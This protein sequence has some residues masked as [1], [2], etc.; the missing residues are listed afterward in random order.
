LNQGNLSAKSTGKVQ[1]LGSTLSTSAA[2]SNMHT[3]QTVSV[4][5]TR[6]NSP[7]PNG[8]QNNDEYR[9]HK[10]LEEPSMDSLSPSKIKLKPGSINTVS[11][12]AGQVF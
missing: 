3:N 2:D 1:M 4:Q 9:N 6:I 12:N 11:K 5:P 7:N 10:F 8:G